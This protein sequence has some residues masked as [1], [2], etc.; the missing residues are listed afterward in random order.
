MGIVIVMAEV[1]ATERPCRGWLM[2][3]I[4]ELLVVMVT[5]GMFRSPSSRLFEHL[6]PHRHVPLTLFVVRMVEG[7]GLRRDHGPLSTHHLLLPYRGTS[8]ARCG[9]GR[10]TA[11]SPRRRGTPSHRFGTRASAPGPG[12]TPFPAH[13]CTQERGEGV[14]G[15]PEQFFFGGTRH[16][17][18]SQ[19]VVVSG[20]GDWLK[21]TGDWAGW[22]VGGMS[23]G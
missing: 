22:W 6:R 7:G 10:C 14:A 11:M 4:T 5:V 17:N 16:H 13:S 8:T 9:W 1:I 12:S 2:I 19:G 18:P 15:W 20:S 3:M 21:H 23:G